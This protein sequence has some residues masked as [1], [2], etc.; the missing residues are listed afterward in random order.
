MYTFGSKSVHGIIFLLMLYIYAFYSYYSSIG[1]G[2]LVKI[3]IIGAGNS[4]LA[5]AAHLGLEGHQISMWNRSE[6]SIGTI[7]KT[8]TIRSV[9]AL[10]GHV[11]LHL[12]TTD[13]EKALAD[14]EL[15]LITTPATSHKD[16]AI[17]IA[18][19]IK[20]QT[21]IVLN[22]GRT[23]G[24]LEFKH[25]YNQY[26]NNL[27]QTILETQTI[28][29]TCRKIDDDAVEIYSFKSDVLISTFDAT[30]NTKL[31]EMLPLALQTYLIPAQ[32]MVE[33][34]VGNVGM[35]LHCAPLLLNTG[36]TESKNS[37]YKY[38]FEGIT[39]SIINLVEKI[40]EERLQISRALGCEVETT[41]QW[42]QR[43]Y[44]LTKNTMYQCLQQN[45]AYENIDGPNSL[46]HRYIL[47]DVPCGLVPLESVGHLLGLSMKYTG[48]IIDL[49][50]SLLDIDFRA[51][52][53][54][55]QDYFHQNK[56]QDIRTF[57]RRREDA[58]Q[59]ETTKL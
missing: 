28:I 34:S 17:Q 33:T 59:Q 39:P 3:T 24:A 23:F 31:I 38:Y 19:V 37:T 43:T 16:L 12:I 9:G 51:E 7:I 58:W 11:K 54:N 30:L 45:T 40:D 57:F 21:I 44:G 49:A 32:S 48:L 52:G 50:I 41:T 2:V 14:A 20:H 42:L 29:Y 53:R 27:E 46:R 13:L 36:W 18:K 55:I 8:R 47:E 4:G 6:K 10:R 56:H 15:V 22:P 5:M 1:R 26:N 35:V 25:F